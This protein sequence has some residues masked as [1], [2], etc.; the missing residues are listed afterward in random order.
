MSILEQLTL[1]TYKVYET[2][3]ALESNCDTTHS[4]LNHAGVEAKEVFTIW[5]ME[6]REEGNL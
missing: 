5:P 1:D 6:Q 2:W 3:D 4:Q